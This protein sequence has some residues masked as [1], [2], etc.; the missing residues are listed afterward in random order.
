MTNKFTEQELDAIG[1]CVEAAN[2]HCLCLG[3]E[4][5]TWN[6]R[7]LDTAL[8]ARRTLWLRMVRALRDHRLVE[9]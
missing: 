1:R 5:L 4:S 7:R 2:E 3:Q 9:G 6:A 8:K